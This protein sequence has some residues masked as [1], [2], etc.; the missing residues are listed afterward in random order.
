MPGA[1]D[2][3]RPGL[4][5]G[6]NG[7]VHTDWEKNCTVLSGFPVTGGVDLAL[8]PAALDRRLRG[9]N[10]HLVK[11]PNRFLDSLLEAVTSLQVLGREPDTS[12]IVDLQQ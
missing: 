11:D 5:C 9:E 1:A 7:I 8:H 2:I 12:Y 6:H 3:S 4:R 10:H